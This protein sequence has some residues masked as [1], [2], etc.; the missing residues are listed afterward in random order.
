[1]G[2]VLLGLPYGVRRDEAILI[3][4][5]GQRQDG[6]QSIL[7]DGTVLFGRAQMNVMEQMLGYFVADMKV[8]DAAECA[9][10]LGRKYQAFALN[11]SQQGV[12]HVPQQR[13]F[14]RQF[15]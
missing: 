11:I 8:Q 1:M 13:I 14:A 5:A 2:Q 3:N 9:H 7:A 6:I 15:G 12:S 10:E 4:E